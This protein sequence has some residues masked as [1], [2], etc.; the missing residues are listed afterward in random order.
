M[1]EFRMRRGSFYAFAAPFLMPLALF[2]PVCLALG[3]I[4]T[5]ST[6][7]GVLVA[8]AATAALVGVLAVKYRRMVDGTVVR[9]SPQGV[10][11]SDS[12][13]FRLR[14][15][16]AD[17]E[18]VDVVESPMAGRRVIGR[19]GG[20]RVR[21]GEMRTIGLVG[22]GSRV[23]PGRVPGW[24]RDHLARVPVHPESGLQWL[25]IPLGAIDPLWERGPMGELVRQ[26]RPDLMAR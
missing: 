21:A 8:A 20:V 10:E 24:M 9:F 11:L 18:R 1:T 23:L 3:A 4:L 22:W 5:R 2:F 19:P 14:L 16:W 26:R 6:L 15:A 13:G 25:G 12:Y 17:I 7:L